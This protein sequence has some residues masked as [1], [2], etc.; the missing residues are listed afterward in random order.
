LQN[1][2]KAEKEEERIVETRAPFSRATVELDIL[3]CLSEGVR[4]GY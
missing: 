1:E 4:G 3:G 2:R